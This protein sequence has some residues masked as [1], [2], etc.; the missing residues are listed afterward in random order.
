MELVQLYSSVYYEW[1]HPFKWLTTNDDDDNVQRRKKCTFAKFSGMKK[2]LCLT[3]AIVLTIR[4]VKYC[5][6]TSIC[7]HLPDTTEYWKNSLHAYPAHKPRCQDTFTVNS[8]FFKTRKNKERT[9]GILN[10]TCISIHIVCWQKTLLKS[11]T[12]FFRLGRKSCERLGPKKKQQKQKQQSKPVSFQFHPAEHWQWHSIVLG[13]ACVH[14]CMCFAFLT[15][16]EDHLFSSISH[17]PNDISI[18]CAFWVRWYS[19]SL[20]CVIFFSPKSSDFYLVNSLYSITCKC[21]W[22]LDLSII[23]VRKNRTQNT[24]SIG[25]LFIIRMSYFV[26]SV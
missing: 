17:S 1:Q 24:Y 10:D 9:Y 25:D 21:L 3:I 16:T 19:I 7:D 11:F 13:C 14:I 23:T 5:I 26:G 2:D 12:F 8:S 6:P 15:S 4:I 20:H 18:S 22:F